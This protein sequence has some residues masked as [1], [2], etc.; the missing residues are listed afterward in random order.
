MTAIDCVPSLREDLSIAARLGGLGGSLALRG[1]VSEELTAAG[2]PPPLCFAALEVLA[3]AVADYGPPEL[4][5]QV[6]RDAA[7]IVLDS[8]AE[9]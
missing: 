3:P 2:Y 7:G 6:A 9:H 5:D 1:L 8:G 4:A